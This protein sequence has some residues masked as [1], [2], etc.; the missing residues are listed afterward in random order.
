MR[1]IA[2]YLTEVD[3][4]IALGFLKV[5]GISADV[6]ADDGGGMRPSLVFFTGGYR[7]VVDEKD[8]ER[9]TELIKAI[10]NK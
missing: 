10:D 2:T 7:V 9:A 6:V 5:E 8:A 3:A 4:N 1:T